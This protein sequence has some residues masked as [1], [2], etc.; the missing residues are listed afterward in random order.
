MF[1]SLKSF[2]KKN[3]L[4]GHCTWWP[5]RLFGVD[6]S[7][8]CFG[9]DNGYISRKILDKLKADWNLLLDVWFTASI[10]DKLWKRVAIRANAILMYLGVSTFGWIAWARVGS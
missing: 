6:Y 3:V 8:S 4:A 9:H 10:A 5:D 7:L 2:L 1:Q